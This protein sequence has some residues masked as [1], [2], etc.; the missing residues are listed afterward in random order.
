MARPNYSE[1][2]RPALGRV[3]PPVVLV[4]GSPR[5]VAGVVAELPPGEVV[6]FQMDLH[7]AERLREELA[8]LGRDV[9]VETR[10]DLWDLSADFATAIYPAP[11]R[12][13]RELKIDLVEQVW[14]VLRP[15]GTLLTLSPHKPD[16]LFP[17]LLKKVFGRCSDLPHPDGSVYACHRDPDRQRPRRRHEIVFQARLGDHPP[18]Q[19]A[20]QPGVFTYGRLDDGARA[21]LE[22]ADIQ[23]GN[24]VLDLGCG[25][26]ANGVFAMQRAGP[27]GE[28]YFVDSNVRAAALAER[29]A[30][31]NGLARF[32]VIAA[33]RLEGVPEHYFDVILSN[34]PYFAQE[35]IARLFVERGAYLLR[36]GGRFYLVT[37]QPNAIVEMMGELFRDVAV[38]ERRGYAVFVA[39]GPGR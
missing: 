29:N 24:R 4:L 19:L 36:P 32:K 25:C 23:P 31:E 37:R 7:Q 6:C 28:V 12:G 5:R 11:E 18:L 3:R 22:A 1:L 20:T 9:A 35:S 14:H 38:E 2:L 33:R 30:R 8:P 13:E 16:A 34:P 26:G 15:R 10:P 39:G 27:D 21:L 17:P